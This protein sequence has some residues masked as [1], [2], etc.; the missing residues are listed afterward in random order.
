MS[1]EDEKRYCVYLLSSAC[2]RRTYIGCTND[3]RR[4][5]RQHNGALVGG[6]RATRGG[7][8][9]R[10]A[11]AVHGLGRSARR[12]LCLEWALKH[13]RRS[14]HL[15]PLAAPAGRSFT[16][17]AGR[18]ALFALA[19]QHSPPSAPWFRPKGLLFATAAP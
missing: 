11:A 2:G 12:A 9:W 13:W 10:V 4:R 18:A 14:R 16:G 5:L 7:R 1:G 3:L 15:R 8:P 17:A 6:A 19:A